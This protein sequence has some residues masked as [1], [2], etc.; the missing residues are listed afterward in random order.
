M[1]TKL[2]YSVVSIL[3]LLLPAD[4]AAKS[5]VYKGHQKEF[6][7][8][9]VGFGAAGAVL[10]RKLSDGNKNSVLVLEAGENNILDPRTLSPEP[11]IFDQTLVYD[12]SF[13]ATYPVLAPAG[14]AVIYSE[15][16]EW[17]GGAAHNDLQVV[18][19]VPADYNQWAFDSN[20][21][22]WLY[23]NVLPLMKALEKYT[24]DDTIADPTQRGFFGPISVTQ[25]PPIDDDEFAIAIADVTGSPI[26]SDYNN[27]LLSNVCTGAV[28]QFVTAGSN[29]RRSFSAYD[30]TPIDEVMD[31]K[32]R[33]L[34]GRKLRVMGN[35]V[36][37]RI[38]FD[39]NKA[40][41]VQYLRN[42]PGKRSEQ[43]RKVYAK[44]KIILCAG[45]I[46]TP[47]IL[48]LSGIGDAAMLENLGI[49]VVV[50]NPNVGANLQNQ[51][52]A[53]AMLE[54]MEPVRHLP[55]GSIL[56]FIDERPYMPADSIRRMQLIG[57]D[58][59]EETIIGGF[60]MQPKSRGSVTITSKDP[61]IP[62]KVSM[63][64]YT[65]G[66]FSDV[67]SDAY[68]VVSFFKIAREIA[69]AADHRVTY[70]TPE[71]YEAGDEALFAAALNPSSLAI[72]YHNVGTTRMGT[73]I[74]NGVVD[75]NL[76]VMGTKGLMVGDIGV[77]S[78]IV[79]GNTCYSAYVIALVAAKILGVPT[80]PAL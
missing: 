34:N 49:D 6:D 68:L 66:T 26:V 53:I 80:P 29:S 52:G 33:G 76:H 12:P 28:Q 20:N 7:Y 39:G 14:G 65:D 67:G 23:S 10:A 59:P 54:D 58:T 78:I 32:G 79:S 5:K 46:N 62:A 27:A 1:K 31:E 47:K 48:M 2:F 25:N 3:T 18:R 51:Y 50:N 36:V 8:I 71:Q 11:F 13:A 69:A 44:K 35:A 38:L 63:N 17:G 21:L 40:I 45:A 70:P 55:G 41:G 15:G 37:S 24:P 16:R 77:E 42:L 57:V 60:L 19:G 61:L 22:Q 43:V 4:V 30:F 73:S 64:M 74:A 56:S 75:G 9:I 72:T